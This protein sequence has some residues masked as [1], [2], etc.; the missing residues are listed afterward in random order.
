M[1][2]RPSRPRRPRSAAKARSAAASAWSRAA[3]VARAS[4]GQSAAPNA[5]APDARVVVLGS[6]R[7][8]A[9]AS[10]APLDAR[11][12]HVLTLRDDRIVALEQITDTARW[13]GALAGSAR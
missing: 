3:A 6:Y 9:R 10:G 8:T 1:R 11:F 7:G 2:S 5:S 13:H 4:G 12:A